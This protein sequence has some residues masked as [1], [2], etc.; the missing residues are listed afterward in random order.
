MKKE[1]YD[2]IV[3]LGAQCSCSQLL[4][5]LN[6][7][8]Y[9]FPFDWLGGGE[10][11]TRVSLV[12]NNFKDFLNLED[13]ELIGSRTNPEPCDIYKN[14]KT[15]IVFNH[16]FQIGM[17]IENTY[18]FVKEKYQR[19]EKRLLNLITQ[20]KKILFMYIEA[21]GNP[22]YSA[23]YIKEAYD[24]LKNAYPDKELYFKYIYLT[25]DNSNDNEY[26][27]LSDNIEMYSFDLAKYNTETKLYDMDSN[28]LKKK[29]KYLKLKRKFS[30]KRFA[31]LFFS[32]KV[33][34]FYDR[35]KVFVK[36]LG[37]KIKFKIKN[38]KY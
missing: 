31:N 9:S 29:F 22:E 19:R 33:Q 17:P 10:L 2:L 11:K 8:D 18:P 30:L 27:K 34:D 23:E 3:S 15:D 4:R 21:L 35:Q 32:Y 26:K 1:K 24:K 28:K 12:I 13:L 38:K 5:S 25:K 14:N 20:S 6:L 16:D 7:Q 37:I 36:I